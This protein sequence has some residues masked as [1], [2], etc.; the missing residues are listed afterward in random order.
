MR[1]RPRAGTNDPR[2][3]LQSVQDAAGEKGLAQDE[4]YRFKARE[5]EARAQLV[6]DPTTRRMWEALARQ[7]H[8]LADELERILGGRP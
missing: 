2:T 7:W 8:E 3:G 5:C 1:A 6:R 4:D